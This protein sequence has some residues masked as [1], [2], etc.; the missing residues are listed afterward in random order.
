[1]PPLLLLPREAPMSSSDE[2]RQYRRRIVA[3]QTVMRRA[4]HGCTDEEVR[5]MKAMRDV[6]RLSF[7]AIAE[8][9]GKSVE[10]VKLALAPTRSPNPNSGRA[11][12][13]T[14]PENLSRL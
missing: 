8:W 3:E 7:D 6:G 4:P 13:N 10:E 11:V 14:T 5:R 1:M 2:Q 12:I 9:E